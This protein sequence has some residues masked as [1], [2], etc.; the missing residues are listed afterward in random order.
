[1]GSDGGYNVARKTS[2]G[3]NLES[4]LTEIDARKVVPYGFVFYFGVDNGI[5]LGVKGYIHEYY[6]KFRSNLIKKEDYGRINLDLTIEG[7]VKITK[8][9]GADFVLVSDLYSKD[10][11]TYWE[12]S[13]KAQLLLNIKSF[14]SHNI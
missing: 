2:D 11:G 6:D 9:K 13:G 12:I 4:S 10:V 8:E 14:N 3:L 1:M 5:N 7:L